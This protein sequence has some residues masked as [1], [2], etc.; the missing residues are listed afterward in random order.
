M[1]VRVDIETRTWIENRFYFSTI[2]VTTAER[3]CSE[4]EIKDIRVQIPDNNTTSK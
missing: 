1:D 3:K 2:F 4:I